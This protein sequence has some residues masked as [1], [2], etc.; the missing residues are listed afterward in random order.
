MVAQVAI[1]I[2]WDL[3]SVFGDKAVQATKGQC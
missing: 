1:D 3:A 2:Y